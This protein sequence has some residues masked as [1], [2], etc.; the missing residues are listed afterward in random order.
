MSVKTDLYVS[1]V[2]K[3]SAENDIM[4][5][6]ELNYN[7]NE[8]NQVWASVY[9]NKITFVCLP[10]VAQYCSRE[11]VVE[12]RSVTGFN[13][14]ISNTFCITK[15]KICTIRNSENK[16]NNYRHHIHK[17]VKRPLCNSNTAVHISCYSLYKQKT[18][19]FYGKTDPSGPTVVTLIEIHFLQCSTIYK[20][21]N[22]TKHTL[23][24]K[25]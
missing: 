3:D 24:I 10:S 12:Q 16:F 18:T 11:I 2:P 1:V 17:T 8:D 25:Y 15:C 19:D 6:T 4:A 7:H 14:H 20:T 5:N 22:N 9:P 21:E 13:T 23:T